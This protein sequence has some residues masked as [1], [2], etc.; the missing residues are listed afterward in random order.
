MK[1]VAIMEGGNNQGVNLNPR[2][3]TLFL[4]YITHCLKRQ[5]FVYFDF[6]PT[7]YYHFI[8]LMCRIRAYSQRLN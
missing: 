1:M 4:L 5:S 3:P 7:K 8:A 6:T 2:G